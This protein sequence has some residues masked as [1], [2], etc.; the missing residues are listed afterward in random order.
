MQAITRL[1]C[2]LVVLCALGGGEASARPRTFVAGDGVR[3]RIDVPPGYSFRTENENGQV[4]VRLENPVWPIF[5]AAAIAPSSAVR[6]PTEEAQRNL[7]VTQAA[8]IL[9]QSKE[10]DYRFIPLNPERGSGVYCLFSAPNASRPEELEP[11]Q[12]L[13]V[14]AGI[15][16]IR[17]AVMYFRIMCNDVTTPEYQEAL[18]LFVNY[19]DEA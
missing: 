9:A 18:A 14:T 3:I 10:Q 16:T 1:V 19:F 2:G 6:A 13:H 12:F 4:I 11:D 15:K 7:L 8:E 5:I 17:G